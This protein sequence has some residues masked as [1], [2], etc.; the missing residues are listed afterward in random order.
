MPLM[1]ASIIYLNVR[2]L[3][4]GGTI[5]IVGNILHLII[6]T[7]AGHSGKIDMLF[8]FV[9]IAIVIY[10]VYN[11]SITLTAFNEENLQYKRRRLI[12]CFLL[13]IIDKAF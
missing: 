2:F 10:I 13:Q 4:Y 8:N 7:V 1:T 3:Y 9:I 5:T 11:V 12:K 6:M